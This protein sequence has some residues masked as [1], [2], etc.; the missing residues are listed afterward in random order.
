MAAALS[1][2][3]NARRLGQTITAHRKARRLSLPALALKAQ[4]DKGHLWRIE[5]GEMEP[6]LARLRSI[7]KALGV[8]PSEL[9]D[10]VPPQS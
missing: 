8:K 9:L 6:T 4:T 7:A 1:D 10:G 3:R 5:A 2:T